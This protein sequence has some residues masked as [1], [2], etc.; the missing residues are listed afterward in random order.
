[1]M[2]AGLPGAIPMNGMFMNRELHQVP[3]DILPSKGVPY[4]QNIEILVA[5][6]RIRERRQLDGATQGTYY[7]KL[8][9]GIEIHGGTAFDKRN[10]CLL[11]YS[12]LTLLEEYT[13][14][15]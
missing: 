12:S 3:L 5:P 9:E 13:L 11:T 8:L 15:N 2:N 1:M 7:E 4:P 14:L 10:F 6:M